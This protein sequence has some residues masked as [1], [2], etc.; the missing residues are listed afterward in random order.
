MYS[1]LQQAAFTPVLP[2]NL[3][4]SMHILKRTLLTD[5]YRYWRKQVILWMASVLLHS[6]QNIFPSEL[7]N[8]FKTDVLP[9]QVLQLL[10]I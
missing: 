4:S 10:E 2:L 9:V 3:T 1:K 8:S 6:Q 7:K 5:T